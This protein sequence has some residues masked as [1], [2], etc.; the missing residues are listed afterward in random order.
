MVIGV[1]LTS[2]L[3]IGVDRLTKWLAAAHL[4]G[5]GSMQIINLGG[6]EVL[7]LTYHENRGAAFS[8]L[9]DKQV[10]LITITSIFLA[11]ILF[12]MLSGRIKDKK[13][14]WAF[15]LIVA[16][17]IGN[18]IDRIANG[19]VIDFIDFRI[20]KFAVFNFADMCAVVGAILLV[21]LVL[22]DEIKTQREKKTHDKTI[23]D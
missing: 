14:L 2:A 12:L 1:L 23:E 20:I 15:G 9:Q 4:K 10:F 16:G 22:I 19:Y 18:L 13:H 5:Q 7:N 11:V 6:H 21:L 8:I 17:G 3:L